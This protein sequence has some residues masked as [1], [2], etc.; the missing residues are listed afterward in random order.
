M[1]KENTSLPAAS[2]A[3]T[4][5]LRVRER[6]SGEVGPVFGLRCTELLGTYD[7]DLQLWKT[8]ER[9]LFEDLPM[10]WDR[11]PRSGMMRNGRIYAQRTWVLRTEGKE[12]GL[13]LTPRAQES[14]ETVDT[15]VKRMGDRTDK[16]AG[17]L[18][19]QVKN[20]K[21]WPTPDCQNHRDGTQMRQ[22]QIDQ[23]GSHALSLHHTVQKWPT[24]H[25]NCSTGAG[26]HGTGGDNLQ[27]EAAKYP[28]PPAR[29]HKSGKGR[30]D[31]GHTPQLP[32]VI[33]GQL[34]PQFVEWLMGY[35]LNYTN[36]KENITYSMKAG[37]QK[38]SP[39]E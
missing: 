18:S 31:N 3:R 26:S 11:L 7:P 32:E 9:S 14:G 27:T 37:F 28:T 13:W 36:I 38:D 5:A 19:A 17:S 35:P 8:L 25:A 1:N 4:S 10:F 29:D 21:T 33:G 15:F 30:K 16:C 24:P 22:A 6:E 20:P 39:K 12:S 2:H 34:N 23:G